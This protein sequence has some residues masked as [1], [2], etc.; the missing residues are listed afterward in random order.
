[1]QGLAKTMQASSKTFIGTAKNVAKN[2]SD[3]MNNSF[4][5][6]NALE[7]IKKV[8][9]AAINLPSG[10]NV[11]PTVNFTGGNI[12]GGLDRNTLVSAFNEA[13]KGKNLAP[14]ITVKL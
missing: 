9:K 11:T 7:Q 5:Y 6:D 13:L 4:N 1:M 10:L 2:V 8:K 14:P 12:N 3:V